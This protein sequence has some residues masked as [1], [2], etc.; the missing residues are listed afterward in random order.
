MAGLYIKCSG[1][2]LHLFT[3]QGS[4]L[5]GGYKIIEF[6]LKIDGF[7]ASLFKALF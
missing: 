2:Y 4:L 5:A 3:S 6:G 7:P 1:K